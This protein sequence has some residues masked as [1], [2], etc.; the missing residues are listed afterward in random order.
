MPTADEIAAAVL[1]RRIRNFHGDTVSLEQ[2]VVATEQRIADAENQL[3]AI[4]DALGDRRLV[5]DK[6]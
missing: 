1:A 2:I 3:R 6:A 5:D 4:R